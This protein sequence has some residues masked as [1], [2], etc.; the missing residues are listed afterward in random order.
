VRI[1]VSLISA[2]EQT[3]LWSDSYTDKIADILK[4]QDEVAEAVAQ[5]LLLNLPPA[6]SSSLS[7]SVDPAGYSSYL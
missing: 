5:K 1:D 7:S 4:V 6:N 3:P 2:R